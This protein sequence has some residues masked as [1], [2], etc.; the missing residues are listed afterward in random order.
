[1]S[2]SNTEFLRSTVHHLQRYDLRQGG[3]NTA[4]F[5]FQL[6]INYE[7]KKINSCFIFRYPKLFLIFA[8]DV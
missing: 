3:G 5:L 1:M 7:K 6:V 8:A 4:S 2:F